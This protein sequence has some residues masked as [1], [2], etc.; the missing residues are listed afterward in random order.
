VREIAGLLGAGRRAMKRPPAL[1]EAVVEAADPSA[2]DWADE[3]ARLSRVHLEDLQG[4][5]QAWASSYELALRQAAAAELEGTRRLQQAASLQSPPP[6]SSKQAASA[7]PQRKS[8]T[9]KGRLDHVPPVATPPWT[10]PCSP[11]GEFKP[12]AARDEA[13]TGVRSPRTTERSTAFSA[14][15]FARHSTTVEILTESSGWPSVQKFVRRPRFDNAVGVLILLSSVLITADVQYRAD[16]R[17]EAPFVF[18]VFSV[19]FTFIFLGELLLRAL[20]DGVSFFWCLSPGAVWN[21]LDIV[22]VVAGLVEFV[23][24]CAGTDTHSTSVVGALRVARLVRVARMIR[25]MRVVRSSP[26]FEEL[27]VLLHAILSAGGAMIWSILVLCSL[28]FVVSCILTQ[29]ATNHFIVHGDDPVSWG[30]R[31]I[32][33]YFGSVPTSLL[34]MFL[35]VTGGVNYGEPLRCIGAVHMTYAGVYFVSVAFCLIAMLNIVNGF[36]VESAMQAARADREHKVAQIAKNKDQYM[37]E[38]RRVFKLIDRDG[39]NSITYP[40]FKRC[41]ESQEFQDYLAA[42]DLDI[43]AGKEIF[44]L[45]DVDHD[46]TVDFDEFVGGCMRFRGQATA[47]D[48]AGVR[49]EI[50]RLARRV[51]KALDPPPPGIV[52]SGQVMSYMSSLKDGTTTCMDMPSFPEHRDQTLVAEQ[53]L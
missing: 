20:A 42:F 12:E 6:F 46:G 25:V 9:V 34:T 5:V 37:D 10:P 17:A 47:M 19:M 30:C 8:K 41:V 43:D 11:L 39:S 22:F 16:T 49:Q 13:A 24:M 40:E 2:A 21:F 51:T 14:M 52:H 44:A 48:I 23:F 29:A 33:T 15:A 27:R 32:D 28:L 4:L 50:K 31:D 36:F 38:L 45:L 53:S 7:V 26:I 18:E 35:S 3:V 1:D